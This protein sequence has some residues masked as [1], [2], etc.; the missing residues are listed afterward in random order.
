MLKGREITNEEVR[1]IVR[2]V[3]RQPTMTKE[4]T[5]GSID[6]RRSGCVGGVVVGRSTVGLAWQAQA[7][8]EDCF[9]PPV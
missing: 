9:T 7:H 8:R 6:T 3:G 1:A 4:S 5:N 2:T